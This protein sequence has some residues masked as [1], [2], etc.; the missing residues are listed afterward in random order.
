METTRV[1]WGYIGIMEKKMETRP[2]CQ[3]IQECTHPDVRDRALLYYRRMLRELAHVMLRCYEGIVIRKLC[4][5]NAFLQGHLRWILPSFQM[6]VFS[7][8]G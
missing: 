3:A 1:Y 6:R 5:M 7:I 2:A 8:A 4:F